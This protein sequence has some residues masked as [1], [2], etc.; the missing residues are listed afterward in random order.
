MPLGVSA[1]LDMV[2]RKRVPLERV[3]RDRSRESSPLGKA[4]I[5]KEEGDEIAFQ[6]PGGTRTYEVLAVRFG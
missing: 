2:P 4:I 5:G 1:P 6:A 3:P